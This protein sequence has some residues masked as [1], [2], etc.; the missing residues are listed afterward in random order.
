MR[1]VALLPRSQILNCPAIVVASRIG[2]GY[3][4][5]DSDL[6]LI[7]NPQMTINSSAPFR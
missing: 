2:G 3:L 4:R 1:G 5:H 7:A 6:G